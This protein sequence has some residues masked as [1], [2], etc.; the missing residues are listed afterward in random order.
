MPSVMSSSFL[1]QIFKLTSNF[2]LAIHKRNP[3]FGVEIPVHTDIW[4]STIDKVLH[5]SPSCDLIHANSPEELAFLADG[6]TVGVDEAQIDT[7]E[8]G[9]EGIFVVA[10]AFDEFH[11]GESTELCCVGRAGG[12]GEYV[13]G[14]SSCC[15]EN[16]GHSAVL[17]AGS[18]EDVDDAW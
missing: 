16:F 6:E 4:Q 3:R 12:P 17:G 18:S 5:T 10:V 1:P 7:F 15:G 2:S 9:H 11:I 14:V 13:D 8:G